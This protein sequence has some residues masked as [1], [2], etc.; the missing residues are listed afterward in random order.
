MALN[1][2]AIHEKKNKQTNKQRSKQANKNKSKQTKKQ[3]RNAL[4]SLRH[5]MLMA[6]TVNTRSLNAFSQT[7]LQF[8]IYKYLYSSLSL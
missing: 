6:F 1:E 2:I 8:G 5:R 3:L 7:R 4:T